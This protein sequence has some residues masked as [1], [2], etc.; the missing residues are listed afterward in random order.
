MRKEK[1]ILNCFFNEKGKLNLKTQTS[2]VLCLQY[3]IYKNK[4]III[5]QFKERIRK[6]LYHIKTGFLGTPLILITLFDN[7][8]DDYAYRMLF[9]EHFPGWIYTIN[10]GATTIWERWN[11][12]LENG[13]ISTNNMNSFNHYV[14]GS[15]CES[16]YSRIVGLRN[17]APGWKKVIIKPQLNY[18]IKKINFSYKS[19]SGKY[20]II[21]KWI[22]T[23]FNLFVIIPYGCEAEII[24]PNG[25]IHKVKEGNYTYE[26]DLNKNIY[27]PFSIDTPLI[28]IMKNNEG[29]HIIKKL[30]P[31]I[32]KKSNLNDEIFLTYTIRT[33]NLNPNFNYNSDIIKKCNEELSKIKP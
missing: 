1:A 30:L 23:K 7:G 29:R 12:L 4:D 22:N 32:Y 6:D 16:I 33:I 2:Y 13:T 26:L 24:L 14:Y 19:I 25:I 15:V 8:L 28:D 21:W 5:R 31:K 27:S 11:S 10:L 20:E 3:K 17:N 18:R 9:N